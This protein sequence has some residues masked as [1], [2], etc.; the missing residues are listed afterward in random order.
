MPKGNGS[1]SQA[2][3]H[4]WFSAMYDTVSRA[5]ERGAMGRYR[6]ALLAGL[7]GDVLEIGAGTGANFEHY[8]PAARVLAFEPDP[9]MFARAEKKLATSGRSNIEVRRAPGE[10]LPVPDASYDAVVSTL[11][12][13]TVTDL[14][15]SLAEVSRVLRPGGEIY[16]IEHVRAEGLPGFLQDIIKPVWRWVA[17]GC[18]PNRRTASA[19]SAQG[20]D[21][22]SVKR[23]RMMPWMI[24]LI[25]GVAKKR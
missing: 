17:A 1:G 4:R 3:G 20:F 6:R 7:S 9:F 24:P 14:P 23:E 11:V 13:C 19:I 21:L 2:G 22:L 18:N 25:T 12:L 8:G 15:Q 16:F 10:Q 5:E